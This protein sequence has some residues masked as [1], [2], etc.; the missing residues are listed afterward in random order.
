MPDSFAGCCRQFCVQWKR[1]GVLEGDIVR[2]RLEAHNLSY[3]NNPREGARSVNGH[4]SVLCY[5]LVN[6]WGKP[7]DAGFKPTFY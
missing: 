3:P 2:I 5:R 7:A 6:R 4:K 1:A